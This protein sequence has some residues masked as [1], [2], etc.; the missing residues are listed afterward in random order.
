MMQLLEI[1][2]FGYNSRAKFNITKCTDEQKNAFIDGCIQSYNEHILVPQR[3][4]EIVWML[5][6]QYLLA[7]V[8][9]KNQFKS[10]T[11]RAHCRDV[12]SQKQIGFVVTDKK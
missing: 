8:V 11:W 5:F 6:Q 10:L 3:L 2:K 9:P 1:T 7:R 12:A 4:A